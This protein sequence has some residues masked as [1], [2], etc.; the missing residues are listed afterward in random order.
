MRNS[1]LLL[2][3][4]RGRWV[5][6]FQ[7]H[8]WHRPCVQ[9][10]R[11]TV[12]PCLASGCVACRTRHQRPKPLLPELT[13]R[14]HGTAPQHTAL[15]LIQQRSCCSPVPAKRL[16]LT[17]PP[18][19][20]QGVAFEVQNMYTLPISLSYV[21]FYVD[22]FSATCIVG[23]YCPTIAPAHLGT[24]SL[25]RALRDAPP[26]HPHRLSLNTRPRQL[27][28][29]YSS[30]CAVL[31]TGGVLAANR[32]RR[33]RAPPR[34]VLRPRALDACLRGAGSLQSRKRPRLAWSLPACR[35]I[36]TCLTVVDL[37]RFPRRRCAAVL[38]RQRHPAHS[39]PH[40]QRHA[41]CSGDVCHL[42]R[43]CLRTASNLAVRRQPSGPLLRPSHRPWYAPA[44]CLVTGSGPQ[45][46][47]DHA[48]ID[49]GLHQGLC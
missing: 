40:G 17:T 10:Q 12:N 48:F 43:V 20:Q 29:H 36:A 44:P 1:D 49:R 31:S 37:H 47:C 21:V 26:F 15:F 22:D 8:F 5:G 13:S 27:G 18:S 34:A 2:W 32:C 35:E 25:W 30:H 11:R 7:H 46:L 45:P 6:E 4:A 33:C 41:D 23:S 24:V 42:F 28:R 14:V 16:T 9:Q 39:R 3:S 19:L 38:C